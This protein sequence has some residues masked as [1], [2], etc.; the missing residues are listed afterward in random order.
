MTFQPITGMNIPRECAE[1]KRVL[2]VED[3][4][5]AATVLESELERLGYVVELAE[6]GAEAYTLIRENPARADVII[7][8]R[9]MPVMDGLALTRRIKADPDTADLPVIL[10]TG[11]TETGDISAGLEAGAFYYITKPA[12]RD[13]VRSVLISAVRESARRKAVK[14]RLDNHQI[15]FENIDVLKMS[16][17]RPDE[18][19]PVASL[20]ASI[21]RH[22]EKIIQG[23]FELLQNAVE[24]G[25]LR[26]GFNEKARLLAEGTWDKALRDRASLPEYASGRVEATMLRRTNGLVLT[27]EDN[28]PGFNWRPYLAADPS[29][30][31]GQSGRGIVRA[32]AFVFDKLVYSE[33][34]NKVTAAC[35]TEKSYKW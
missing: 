11:A 35:L 8:D 23:I 32:R 3:D 5:V 18:V 28:G 7:T 25:V 12:Q 22:P 16:L 20:L 26:F 13:L 1:R 31:L 21:H 15:A 27:V 17:R 24:H 19:E 9:M 6:N 29:R 14:N 33:T 2:L 4:R 30:A 10:L 34:G